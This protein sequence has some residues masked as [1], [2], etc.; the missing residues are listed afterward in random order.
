MWRP[1]GILHKGVSGRA[2][3]GAQI[4]ASHLRLMAWAYER[5]RDP[6][7]VALPWKLVNTA[8]MNPSQP[9]GSRS[10]GLIF[11]NLPWFLS[12]LQRW[13]SPTPDPDIDFSAKDASISLVTG[14]KSVVTILLKNL[15]SAPLTDLRVSFTLRR[16]FT[17]TPLGTTPAHLEPGQTI[18]IPYEIVAPRNVNLTTDSNRIAYG[19]WSATYRRMENTHIG[20]QPVKVTL[21]SPSNRTDAALSR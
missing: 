7:Y 6:L 9:F 17:T 8:Y 2:K 18:E 21:Q 3:G 4:V 5:T 11:N 14:A 20:H 15:G 1:A 13:G 12:A 16:D 19:H 10:T